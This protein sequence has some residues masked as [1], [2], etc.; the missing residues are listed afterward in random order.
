MRTLSLDEWRAKERDGYAHIARG[1]SPELP[2]GTRCILT[3]EAVKV[4]GLDAPRVRVASTSNRCP[5][6]WILRRFLKVGAT[7]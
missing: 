5:L 1:I 2:K 3:I 4:A 6:C 7:C